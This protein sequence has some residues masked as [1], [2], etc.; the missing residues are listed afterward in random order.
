MGKQCEVAMIGAGIVGL[1]AGLVAA[2]HPHEVW[3]KIV[4]AMK[5]AS[6]PA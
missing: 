5:I 3:G 1:A 2:R 4:V 6:F